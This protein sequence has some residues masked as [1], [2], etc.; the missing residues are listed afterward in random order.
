MTTDLRT[1]VGEERPE[2]VEDLVSLI[3]AQVSSASGL[4]GTAL[5]AAYTAA[6]KVRP[7]IIE[8]ATTMMVPDVLAALDPFW[9][10]RTAGQSFG[11][12]LAADPDAAAEALLAVADGQVSSANPALGRAY[13][14]MRGRAKPHVIDAL[15]G[16]GDAIER[17]AG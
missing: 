17:H 3:D 15:P 16:V 8:Y 5:R 9:A 10:S 2:L 12:H 1:A 4:G 6:R 11:A 7:G 14:S 13:R